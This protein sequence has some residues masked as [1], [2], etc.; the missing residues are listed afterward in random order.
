MK[1]MLITSLTTLS[2]LLP[3]YLSSGAGAEI[4]KPLVGVIFG[5]MITCLVLEFIALPLFYMIFFKGKT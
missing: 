5:G 1:P 4:Q 3:M 2:G